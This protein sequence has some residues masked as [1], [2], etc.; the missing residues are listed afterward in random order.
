M[1]DL[2]TSSQIDHLFNETRRFAPSESFTASANATRELYEQAAADREGF[3]AE[4]AR[5]L[6]WHTPFTE[7]LDWSN[8][9]FAGGSPTA[10]STSPTTASTD[11]SKRATATASRSCGR[12]SPATRAASRT[13]S[14]PTRS[15]GSPTSSRIWESAPRTASPSTCR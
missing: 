1:S 14:S 11:T 9:P 4:Q 12:A 15:S 8:P 6:H 13:P 5:S 7:V 2:T 3:W 10:S